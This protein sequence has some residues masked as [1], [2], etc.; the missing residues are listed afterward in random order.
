M[1]RAWH[2]HC[3]G[4]SSIPGLRTDIPHPSIAQ[5][6]KKK[7]MG[8]IMMVSEFVGIFRMPNLISVLL[9]Q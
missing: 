2:F 8:F 7:V 3:S 1:D 9:F 6:K 5:K 4:P